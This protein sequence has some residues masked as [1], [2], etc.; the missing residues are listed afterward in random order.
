MVCI[1]MA[2][3]HTY[4]IFGNEESTNIK[5]NSGLAM[6]D[7]LPVLSTRKFACWSI[8][9]WAGYLNTTMQQWFK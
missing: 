9:L 2:K 7:Y 4:I 1:Y 3:P 5:V 6:Q 8:G